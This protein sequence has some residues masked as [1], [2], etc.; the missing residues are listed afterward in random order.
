MTIKTG[1]TI[2]G[3][4]VQNLPIVIDG[5]QSIYEEGLKNGTLPEGMT[6][7][8]FL[9]MLSVGV[10][11]EEV[12]RIVSETV[13]A[14]LIR[15]GLVNQGGNQAGTGTN[16]AVT[17]TPAPTQPA[18]GGTG[19]NAAVTPTPAP[20]QP[21]TGGTGTNAAVTPTPAP[22]QP[23]VEAN[24]FANLK[25]SIS[26]FGDSTNARIGDQA[27]ALAK[28]ENLP[29]IN[30]AQGGSLASYA[31]MSMNGSPV[32]IKFKTDT[33]PAKGRNVFI[34]AEL[35]YGEGVTPFSLHST[36]VVIDNRIEA[37]IVGQTA[38]V[39]IYPRDEQAH[40]IVV[41]QRYPVKLKNN[42]GT[43]GICVLATAKNDINGAN[44]GNWQA[45]LERSKTYV[46]KCIAL[47]EPKESPRYI[48]LPIW[49]DN[50]QGW[51]KENHPYRHQ[52]KD[53]FNNWLRE[54]YGKNV[55]D[56]EAYMLSEQIW[57]D[58]G[59]IPNNAD[60]QAQKEGILPLS[61]SYDGGSHFLPAVEAIIAGKIIAKAKELNY[62]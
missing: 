36:I 56:I 7:K 54:K 18:T 16:A 49:A 60:K 12:R 15:L 57:T 3:A 6:Y 2:I 59:I 32:D 23:A 10:S 9:D 55:Y 22:T 8:Q 45:A 35:V 37:S 31:L 62:L 27:I 58:T 30:N 11:D 4:V 40:S 38:N 13:S 29:V 53:Q 42:G 21:A 47:V 33:I 26:F 14:E 19:T 24:R 51:E 50:N 43:D 1:G 39:K 25:R 41:G 17:P 34:E 5:R 52:L 20:T 61:L 44:W 46:E 28:A 48:V